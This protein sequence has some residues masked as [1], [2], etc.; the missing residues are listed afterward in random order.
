MNMRSRSICSDDFEDV[1][2]KVST[3]MDWERPSRAVSKKFGIT[4]I[5]ERPRNLW[6]RD[7]KSI[8]N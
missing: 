1:I 2:R 5:S 3:R 8:H 7:F 4:R 6:L